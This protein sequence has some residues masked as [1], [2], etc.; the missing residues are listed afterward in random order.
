MHFTKFQRKNIN[1]NGIFVHFNE[2][3][4][5]SNDKS[6]CETLNFISKFCKFCQNLNFKFI[7]TKFQRKNI[8]CNGIFAHFNEI[9]KN[10]KILQI[11]T[12]SQFQM[13]N[14]QFLPEYPYSLPPT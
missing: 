4:S 14:S 8:N 5:I 10:F 6:Q 1:L 3:V 7:S 12:K 11:L 13:E 9:F 2:E